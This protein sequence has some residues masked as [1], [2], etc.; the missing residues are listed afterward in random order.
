M[1]S[2]GIRRVRLVNA[3]WEA[4][5]QAASDMVAAGRGSRVVSGPPCRLCG[6]VMDR[7]GLCP[8]CDQGR[9]DL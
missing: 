7:W 4:R 2:A 1:S 9:E 6:R 8:C 5:V 3:L